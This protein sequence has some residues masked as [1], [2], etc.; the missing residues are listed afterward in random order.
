MMEDAVDH[1][2]RQTTMRRLSI[3]GLRALSVT[4]VLT[5]LVVVGESVF[6][7]LPWRDNGIALATMIFSPVVLRLAAELLERRDRDGAVIGLLCLVFG[8][9]PMFFAAQLPVLLLIWPV[10]LGVPL[11]IIWFQLGR[12]PRPNDSRSSAP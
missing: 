9:T 8:P 12:A 6:S 11:V 7:G 2:F 1:H 5:L 3:F 10:G 4:I